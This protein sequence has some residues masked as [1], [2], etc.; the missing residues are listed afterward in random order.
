MFKLHSRLELHNV[1]HLLLNLFQLILHLNDDF[2]HFCV[3]GL[4]AQR[5]DFTPHLLSDKSEFLALSVTTFHRTDKIFQ[6]IAQALLLF[7]HV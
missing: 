1:Q 7:V 2:L 6:M 3:I 4:A 5:I